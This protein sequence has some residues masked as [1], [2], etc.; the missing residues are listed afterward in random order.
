[1]YELST[2]T[3]SV[4]DSEILGQDMNPNANTL[5]KSAV[6]RTKNRFTMVLE[7]FYKNSGRNPKKEFFNAFIIR[8]IKRALRNA[9]K[10]KIPKNTSIAID[11]NNELEL[12]L[13]EKLRETFLED[14]KFFRAIS[15]TCSGPLT[16]GKAKRKS[17]AN[18]GQPKSFNNR[19]C[20]KFFIN[21]NTRRV[22]YILIELLFI[23]LNPAQLKKKFSFYCCPHE[24]HYSECYTKWGNLKFYLQNE[25]FYNLE[26]TKR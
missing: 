8:S 24:R 4:S 20:R 5:I 23:D 9:D 19:F 13:W 1:M 3:L 22:Y 6:G 26:V 21:E 16:D 12:L 18:R 25:Y 15:T 14:P 10:K 2:G 7:N 17:T 11:A